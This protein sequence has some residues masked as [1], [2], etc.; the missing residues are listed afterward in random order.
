MQGC[1]QTGRARR[2]AL[3]RT[4]TSAKSDSH[5]RS[6]VYSQLA[7][8]RVDVQF[9]VLLSACAQPASHTGL[10]HCRNCANLEPVRGDV[11]TSTPW[12]FADPSHN[13][14]ADALPS[15][16]DQ[17][18]IVAHCSSRGGAS[19]AHARR[20]HRGDT[21]P[22]EAR[23]SARYRRGAHFRRFRS[24]IVSGRHSRCL[25]GPGD[26]FGACAQARRVSACALRRRRLRPSRDEAPG[27]A[28]SSTVPQG[29]RLA[30]NE[31][32]SRSRPR[33]SQHH[34]RAW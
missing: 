31:R 10:S 13:T 16:Q 4:P 32:P 19:H 24:R 3:S 14:L 7:R 2:G 6:P 20:S 22:A 9:Q 18:N 21:G 12:H 15:R 28:C 26:G 27:S 29:K 11:C 5:Q 33:A 17:Q 30:G 25:C 1:A 8:C 34:T 23:S